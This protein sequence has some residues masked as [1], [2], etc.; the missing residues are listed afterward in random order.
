MTRQTR[1]WQRR[2]LAAAQADGT[3]SDL[4]WFVEM[5]LPPRLRP[6]PDARYMPATFPAGWIPTIPATLD[7]AKH[8]AGL[9]LALLKTSNQGRGIQFATMITDRNTLADNGL[10]YYEWGAPVPTVDTICTACGMVAPGTAGS[11]LGCSRGCLATLEESNGQTHRAGMVHDHG[12][13][14]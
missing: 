2:I 7:G 3:L 4:L 9:L 12:A 11:A 1:T 14:L 5:D 6:R 13:R 8:W 10:Y